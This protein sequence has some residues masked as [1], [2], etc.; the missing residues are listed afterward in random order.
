MHVPV[1]RYRNIKGTSGMPLCTLN[2]G[3]HDAYHG[4]IELLQDQTLSGVT[5]S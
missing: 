1:D 2:D 5:A 3:Y 4:C